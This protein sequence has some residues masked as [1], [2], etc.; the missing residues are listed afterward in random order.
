MA[1]SRKNGLVI[2]WQ[3][4]GRDWRWHDPQVRYGV[5]RRLLAGQRA[6]STR[7]AARALG[8]SVTDPGV[9]GGKKSVFL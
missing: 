3:R 5:Q 7:K 9:M 2:V 8:E 6:S 4:L 1:E